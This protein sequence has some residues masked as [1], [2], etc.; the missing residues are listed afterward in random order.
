V[1][2]ACLNPIAF[3]SS[4][5]SLEWIHKVREEIDEEVKRKGMTPAEWIRAR[6]KIDGELLCQKLGLKNGTIVKENV[7]IRNSTGR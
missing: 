1:L 2:W 7:R 4:A 3:A 6:G 5:L